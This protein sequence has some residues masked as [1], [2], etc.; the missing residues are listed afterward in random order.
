MVEL[1]SHWSKV[2]VPAYPIPFLSA[3]ASE[4][5]VRVLE[6]LPSILTRV[7]VSESVGEDLYN[8]LKKLT[9]L[10]VQPIGRLE[11]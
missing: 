5:T 2:D 7:I 8:K 11:S 4:S 10:G 1:V 6:R 9:D 3:M